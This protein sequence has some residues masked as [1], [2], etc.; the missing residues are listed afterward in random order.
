MFRLRRLVFGTGL[1]ALALAALTAAPAGAGGKS[2]AARQVTQPFTQ[3][4]DLSRYFLAPGGDFESG[5]GWTLGGG[6]KIVAGNESFYVHSPSDGRSLSLGSSGWA[7]TSSMCVDSDELTM[8]FFARNTGSVLSTLTVEARI[9][10]TL[11][12]VTTQTTLPVTVVPGVTQTWAPSLPVVFALSLN[13]L[14]GGTTSI[15]FRFTVVGGGGN[16]QIDDVY[17]DPF[18]DRSAL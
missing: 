18:K 14:L 12:G 13:Q 1:I 10:T 2:C 9:Q 11:L 3:W 5:G 17:V 15:D 6:A 4:L 7:R 8:R 16:W